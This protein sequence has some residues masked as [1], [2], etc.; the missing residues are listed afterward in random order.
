[1]RRRLQPLL[2]I[3][4]IALAM[5]I[6]A[7][8]AMSWAAGIAASDPLQSAGICHNGATTAPGDEGGDGQAHDGACTICAINADGSIDAPKADATISLVRQV[9]RVVWLDTAPTLLR[10]PAGSNTQ[11]RAPPQST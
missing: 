10:S 3:F 7:P 8:I 1:M 11:A 9:R 4:L 5:Q 6:L 2:P